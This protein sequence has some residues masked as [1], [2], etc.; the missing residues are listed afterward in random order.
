M[1]IHI[2]PKLNVLKLLAELLQNS[3]FFGLIDN[4]AF[5]NAQSVDPVTCLMITP[6]L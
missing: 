1:V 3:S 5:I 2:P 4:F 6:R